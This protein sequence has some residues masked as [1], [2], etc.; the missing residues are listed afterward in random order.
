MNGIEVERS[1]WSRQKWVYV[2]AAVLVGQAVVVALVDRREPG[3]SAPAVF[4][5]AIRIAPEATSLGEFAPGDPAA[6]ALPS[7][8]GFSRAGWLAFDRPEFKPADW[9]E[10][11]EWLRL[12]EDDLGN[13][14]HDF[15]LS[16]TI[17]PMLIANK[18]LPAL[19]RQESLV[20]SVPLRGNSDILIEGELAGWNIADPKTLPSWRNTELLTNSVVHAI[21]DQGGRIV[22]A[23]LVAGSGS[24]EADAA[25]VRTTQTARFRP[26]TGRKREAEFTSGTL[27]F[28]WHTLPPTNAPGAIPLVRP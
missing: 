14:L 10:P 23:T 25:A 12:D 24:A 7:W 21:V 5:L 15:I 26:R 8:H 28:R 20:S 13:S 16:N 22:A 1:G 27:V 9:T 19:S 6:F 11:P 4:N 3:P 18:P 17:P 2:I